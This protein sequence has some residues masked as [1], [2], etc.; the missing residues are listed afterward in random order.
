M[1]VL[2]IL[3]MTSELIGRACGHVF[4]IAHNFWVLS[5]LGLS[6]A[7]RENGF[8]LTTGL[9]EPSVLM[10]IAPSGKDCRGIDQ[11]T[12]ALHLHSDSKARSWNTVCV[13]SLGSQTGSQRSFSLWSLTCN[14]FSITANNSPLSY[15]AFISLVL[16]WSIKPH[17]R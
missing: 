10:W 17:A 6:W 11:A 5:C 13:A 14:S 8:L 7:C 12:A 9:L 2:L 1:N 15:Q 16:K 4:S 3:F